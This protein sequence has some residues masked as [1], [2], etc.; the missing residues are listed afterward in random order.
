MKYDPTRKQMMVE[1]EECGDRVDV[2]TAFCMA[3]DKYLCDRCGNQQYE[4]EV[5]DRT[6]RAK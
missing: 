5:L 4:N 2:Q 6:R 3:E 1:C